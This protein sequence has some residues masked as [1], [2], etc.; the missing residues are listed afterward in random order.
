MKAIVFTQYGSPNVLKLKD[1]EKPVPSKDEVLVKVFA[2]SVNPLDWH[3]MRAKPIFMRFMTGL[4]KPKNTRL[5]ADMAG[6]VESIGKNIKQFRPGD[7]VF[8]DLYSFGFCAFSEYVCVPVK[9]IIKMPEN[10]TFEEA[11]AVPAA[12]VTALQ[13]LRDQLKTKPGQ[14]ILINGAS[15]GV[16]TFAVQIAKSF[17]AEVAGVC[18]TR[19]LDM[20]RSLGADHVIDYTKED[21]TQAG[22]LYDLILDN[23]GNRS[24]SDCKRALKPGGFY[25][26]NGYSPRMVIQ[27]TRQGPK[28][29][30]NENKRMEGSKEIKTNQADLNFMKELLES[31]KVKPVIDRCYS[32]SEV[33]DAIRYLEEGHARGKVVITVCAEG[34]ARIIPT[35]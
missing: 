19:N 16:G 15:G 24:L 34:K 29:L 4:I 10:L 8:G 22:E 28:I 3:F 2:A 21:F 1:L 33:P 25:L 12:G 17:G 9:A 23:V 7:E 26:L 32:L 31:G 35:K 27:L 13:C 20:V 11:A 30:K 14:K 18:S 6:Q 5:G